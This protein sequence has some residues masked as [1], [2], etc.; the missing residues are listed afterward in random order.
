MAA[1][2]D[3]DSMDVDV[4][5]NFFQDLTNARMQ[6]KD[7][8]VGFGVFY[9]SQRRKKILDAILTG[10]KPGNEDGL[11]I[12]KNYRNQLNDQMNRLKQNRQG[13]AGEM[14]QG[15]NMHLWEF[16]NRRM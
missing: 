15:E 11:R 3:K 5:F 8:K 1:A 6:P 16:M 13:S 4:I 9:S 7:M 10:N 14:P 12:L 2:V